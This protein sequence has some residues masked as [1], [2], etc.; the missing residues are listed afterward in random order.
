MNAKGM[1]D[2]ETM[3][4]LSQL[5]PQKWAEVDRLTNNAI[6]ID[7]I[8]QASE[9][10]FNST[11]GNKSTTQTKSEELQEDLAKEVY[12]ERP[13]L[14]D[15]KDELL[16]GNQKVKDLSVK[17]ATEDADIQDV[18]DEVDRVYE[19]ITKTHSTL[20]RSMRLGMA[21][22]MTKDLNRQLTTMQRQRNITYAEYLAEKDAI[23]TEFEFEKLAMEE[24]KQDRTERLN[25]LSTMFQS[26]KKD[27][28]WEEQKTFEM[29]KLADARKYNDEQ[30][31]KEHTRNLEVL[32]LGQNF[33]REE[34]TKQREQA[35]EIV[36]MQMK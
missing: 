31:I 4:R 18:Q 7:T 9:R 27:E 10:L 20:P 8:N 22:A 1:I 13:S 35:M 32:E 5:N 12:A 21:A 14:R 30:A 19:D 36:K 3:S 28:D 11:T 16:N 6:E 24:E 34:S 17:L 26:A 15:R 23:K 2:T 25:Y 33:Q 29:E